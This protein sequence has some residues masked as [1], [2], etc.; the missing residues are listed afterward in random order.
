[1]SKARCVRALL[2]SLFVAGAVSAAAAPIAARD[3]GED[4]A[5]IAVLAPGNW[6]AL[7]PAG[8]EVDAIYGD[9]VLH[10]RR[11]VAVVGYPRGDRNANLHTRAVGGAL[12]DLTA[13]DRPSD[14]LTAFFPGGMGQNLSFAGV[15]VDGEPVAGAELDRVAASG[16]RVALVLASAPS[17]N[18]GVEVRYILAADAEVLEIESRF[19][20]RAE[21]GLEVGL[22]DV[23]RVDQNSDGTAITRTPDG[24]AVLY[25]AFDPWFGQAYGVVAEGLGM[26]IET[27]NIRKASA[28]LTY[29]PRG[30][31]RVEIAPGETLV[32]RRFVIPGDDLLA[33]KGALGRLQGDAQQEYQLSVRDPRGPVAEAEVWVDLAGEP[34]GFGRTDASG[35]LAFVLPADLDAEAIARVSS[36]GR[37]QG[38][39]ALDAER[40]ETTVELKE[41]AW[42]TGR[43]VDGEGSPI[44]A[45]IQF[46][47]RLGTENPYF[48]PDTGEYRVRNLVYTENG[49]FRQALAPGMYDAVVSRGPEYDAGFVEL[50]TARGQETAL[51]VTLN[52]SVDTT[53]WV[54]ADFHSHSSPSGDNT[55]SQLGRVLNLLAEHIEFAPCTEHQR[56]SSYAPH[57]ERLGAEGLMATC[58]GIELTSSPGGLNHHNAFPLEMHEHTQ[59]GG[60]PLRSLDP[61]LQIE[62]LALWDD[63]SEKLVQQ[64]HPD[65]ATLFFDRDADGVEDGGHQHMFGFMDVI[66]VHPLGALLWEPF[67]D[68]PRPQRAGPNRPNRLHAWMQ[69][70]NQGHRIPGVVN[71]DAHYNFNGSGWLRNYLQSST[72]DPARIDTLEMVH[73]AEAGHL[74]MTNGPFLEVEARAA[75]SRAIPG[76]DLA[77]PDGNVTLRVKVQTPNWLQ[78][79]RVQV[80]VS[81]RAPSDLTFSRETHGAW[82]ADGVVEFEQ[83]IAVTLDRDEHLMVAAIGANAQLGPPVG[84]RHSD[85]RPIA[86]SN[87]IFVD[88]DGGG[89]EANGDTLG[90]PVTGRRP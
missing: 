89:F 86:L 45:K 61:E 66:E 54:S 60:A 87:P 13:R 26:E 12:L 9:L 83:E 31:R 74:V 43:I 58:T 63:N 24:R 55:S 68:Q 30:R 73:A 75:G 84:P 79:D 41:P 37:G 32:L 36:L 48:G 25:T 88:V 42:V 72:D 57:L 49:R 1:M 38:R 20:N 64:N 16:G 59:D 46:F 4:G 76:D 53:G 40:A 80:M 23:I 77:A 15:E 11:I 35:T 18:P 33:V 3:A 82:F 67:T 51:D 56:L 39:I 10:N 5:A 28:Q 69:M 44:P 22:E 85:D 8:K 47:G 90:A 27:L 71:T 62:R 29:L 14:Q 17:V 50:E 70:L 65:F 2:S 52:R 19:H 21:R 7:A 6:D 78:I 34:Y 81:G